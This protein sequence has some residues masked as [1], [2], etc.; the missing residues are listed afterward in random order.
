[1]SG[2]RGF[3]LI[4]L[5]VGLGLL[6]VLAGMTVLSVQIS[7]AHAR[8][9]AAMAQVTSALRYARDTAIAQRRSIDVVFLEPNR[10]R[11]LRNDTDGQTTITDVRL[12]YGAVFER[13]PGR[14]DTPD[15]FGDA[16]A[17]DFGAAATVRF[18]PDGTLTDA[19]EI[20]VNGTV[21]LA[22]ANE[23]LSARA[24]TVSGGSGRAQAYRWTGARWEAR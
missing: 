11:L 10:I 19:A 9:D 17:I 23:P 2:Q 12:D 1:M 13:D 16:A 24:V 21:F 8:G 7:M 20:P 6:A 15:A 4:E 3:T 22:R 14:P 5:Q 18:L